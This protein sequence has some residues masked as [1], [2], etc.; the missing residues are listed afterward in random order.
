MPTGMTA[1][2]N[3]SNN[4]MK[5]G[6]LEI[7]VRWNWPCAFRH[8]VPYVLCSAIVTGETSVASS[9]RNYDGTARG[10]MC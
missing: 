7:S 2:W 10:L 4:V 5:Y 3:I 1:T 8:S 9:R 6:M